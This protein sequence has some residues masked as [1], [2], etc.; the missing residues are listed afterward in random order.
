MPEVEPVVADFEEV[1]VLPDDADSDEIEGEGPHPPT[2]PGGGPDDRSDVGAID[3]RPV[4]GA[5]ADSDRG[6]AAR[7]RAVEQAVV[8][9]RVVEETMVDEPGAPGTDAEAEAEEN[10]AD[11]DSAPVD[12]PEIDEDAVVEGEPA[13][14][15]AG[16]EPLD[17]DASDSDDD[18]F[19]RLRRSRSETDDEAAAGSDD[20]APAL[21]EAETLEESPAE[22]VDPVA[23]V[24]QEHPT[25]M[26]ADAHPDEAAPPA[27]EEFDHPDDAA[28]P[29][30][31]VMGAESGD[32]SAAQ[33]ASEER[34]T[35]AHELARRLKRLLSD[36]QNDVL[37]RL[38]RTRKRR[39][40]VADLLDELDERVTR[41]ADVVRPVLADAASTEAGQ[42]AQPVDDLAAELARE[43]AVA[44]ADGMVE[45]L[46]EEVPLDELADP[47]RA[48]YRRWKTDRIGALAERYVEAACEP[49]Q[50]AV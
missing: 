29:F 28:E 35:A 6:A 47:V 49:E 34:A 38:R 15:T 42:G 27:S 8:D 44:V 3:G 10:P 37:D 12:G 31:R 46:E 21:S 39:L 2:V 30:G 9:E 24:D 32:G 33:E 20:I 11:V 45:P 48:L 50:S 23:A 1:R 26:D 16:I 17:A 25:E 4:T 36:E 22:R 41:F 14:G 13:G 18:L 43:V 40:V 5:A 7:G 19:A